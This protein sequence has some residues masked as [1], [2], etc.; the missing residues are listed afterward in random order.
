MLDLELKYIVLDYKIEFLIIKSSF[1]GVKKGEGGKGK[2]G[3][4]G[5]D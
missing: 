1:D 3:G 4:Q 5:M 2:E